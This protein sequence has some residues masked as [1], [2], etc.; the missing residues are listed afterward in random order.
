VSSSVEAG[1]FIKRSPSDGR[2]SGPSLGGGHLLGEIIPTA[3][4]SGM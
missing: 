4:L 3:G 1:H 2:T